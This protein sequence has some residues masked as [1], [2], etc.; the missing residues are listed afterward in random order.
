MLSLI[1]TDPACSD[2]G[3]S[4]LS[5]GAPMKSLSPRSAI[6]APKSSPMAGTGFSIVHTSSPVIPS[7]TNT[8]PPLT[9]FTPASAS[10]APT[11][12]WLPFVVIELPKRSYGCGFPGWTN[13]PMSP[14]PSYNASPGNWV[15]ELGR[16]SMLRNSS[17]RSKP[18][19]NGLMSVTAL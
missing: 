6:A 7:K 9:S 16:P 8:A 19:Y 1:V 18:M 4:R 5:P 14:K 17:C 12:M 13:A 10:G 2:Q 15:S 3:L 11:K